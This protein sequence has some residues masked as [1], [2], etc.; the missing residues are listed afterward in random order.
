RCNRLAFIERA[1][2]DQNLRTVR[3]LRYLLRKSSVGSVNQSWA[4]LVRELDC[5]TLW[6]VRSAKKTRLEPGE[7]LNRFVCILGSDFVEFDR[8]VHAREPVVVRLINCFHQLLDTRAREDLERLR[9]RLRLRRMLH[10][11]QEGRE[12]AAMVQVQMA[13]PD[14]LKV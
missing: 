13:N 12:A 6:P 8:K 9:S 5:Q 11:K 1:F 7:N 3:E 14:G 10:A 2:E 4:A